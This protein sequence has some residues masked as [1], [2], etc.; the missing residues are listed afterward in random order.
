MRHAELPDAARADATITMLQCLHE[1]DASMNDASLFVRC[2]LLTDIITKVPGHEFLA[3]LDDLVRALHANHVA[4][5]SFID[6][7]TTAI[8]LTSP[9]PNPDRAG[10]SSHEPPLAP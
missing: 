6:A 8:E 7:L 9:I 1:A 10:Q 2:A 5:N 4:L 3:G